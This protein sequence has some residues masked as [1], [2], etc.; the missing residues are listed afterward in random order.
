MFKVFGKK[1]TISIL[2]PMT[3]EAIKVDEVPDQVFAQKMIGDGVAITPTSGE[4]LA[5]CDGKIIQTFPTN[6]VLGIQTDEGIE[7]LIHIG[8]DTVELAGRG[9]K[10]FVKVG[11]NIKVGDKLLE[12]DLD[13]IRKNGKQIITPVII[14]NVDIVEC[15]EVKLGQVIKG[16]DEIMIIIKRKIVNI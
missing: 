16:E 12:V 13:F 15:M 9:F 14:T 7:I 6:H 2:A 5:P 4:V 1:E 8:L 3:G 10:S 11:D